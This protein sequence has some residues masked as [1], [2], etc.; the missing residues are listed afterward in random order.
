MA[1]FLFEVWAAITASSFPRVLSVELCAVQERDGWCGERECERALPARDFHRWWN[2]PF[3]GVLG[4]PCLGQPHN[5]LTLLSIDIGFVCRVSLCKGTMWRVHSRGQVALREANKI[6]IET[7]QSHHTASSQPHAQYTS[8]QH[9]LAVLACMVRLS[10]KVPQAKNLILATS[11]L[12]LPPHR[13]TTHPI[14]P[15]ADKHGA[16][17][18]R[19]VGGEDKQRYSAKLKIDIHGNGLCGSTT[20]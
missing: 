15:S 7:S 16:Q 4:W 5:L 20:Q 10:K 19:R 13:Q 1:N 14:L 12:S 11:S 8:I 17:R 3:S 18:Q 9:A 2:L 6:P